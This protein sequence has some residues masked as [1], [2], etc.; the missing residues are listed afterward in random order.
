ML[1]KEEIDAIRFYQGDVRK[2]IESVSFSENEKEE[3]FWGIPSA[4]RTMNCLMF[5][6]IDNEKERIAEGTASLNPEIF[7]EIDK[8]VDVFF[9]IFRAMCKKVKADEKDMSVQTLYRTDRGI[10]VQEM[11]RQGRTIS[12]TS[13]SKENCFKKYFQKK[14]QLTLLEIV[15]S[16]G[17]PCLDFEE[18]FGN[19]YYFMTQKEILLPPFLCANFYEGKLTKEEEK[20]RDVDGLPP[21]GKYIVMLEKIVLPEQKRSAQECYAGLQELKKNR[22][23]MAGFLEN[24]MKR[25]ELTE[26]EIKEYCAWKKEFQEIIIEGFRVIQNECIGSE[27]S[28]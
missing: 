28:L 5:D 24:L 11:K 15:V 22:E 16:S 21:Q 13:A 27:D 4:Y 3:G 23:K 1:T 8:V 17:I 25:T 19:D 18:I 9:N 14:R 10:S 6:G 26:Q 2:R 12:L 7:L 20:Y